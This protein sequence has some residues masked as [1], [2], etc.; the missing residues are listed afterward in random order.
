MRRQINV[1]R[2]HLV[3]TDGKVYFVEDGLLQVLDTLE[4]Y[5]EMIALKDKKIEEQ[6]AL[7]KKR[8]S[9]Y[10]EITVEGTYYKLLMV[11]RDGVFKALARIRNIEERIKE[12]TRY[13]KEKEEAGL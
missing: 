2:Q 10:F 9:T 11:N 6:R 3:A 5:K 8:A 7:N 13:F 4:E 1:V 12:Q